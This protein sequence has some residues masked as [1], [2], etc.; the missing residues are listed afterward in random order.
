MKKKILEELIADTRPE[1]ISDR[2]RVV[3]DI[4]GIENFV[5][6]GRYTQG[7]EIYFPKPESIV[8][9]ARNR[10]IRKEYDGSNAANLAQKYD[11]TIKQIWNIL[12]DVPYPGQISID[13]YLKSIGKVHQE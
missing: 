12:R 1:D 6:L 10:R 7:D 8:V 13:D 2:Y 4:I 5:K 3:I 9:P 11:L